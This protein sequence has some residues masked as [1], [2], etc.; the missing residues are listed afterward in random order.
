VLTFPLIILYADPSPSNDSVKECRLLG[1]IFP[2]SKNGTATE[3]RCF[4]RDP[5]HDVITTTVS[6]SAV[7]GS[8]ESVEFNQSGVT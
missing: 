1:N 4:L 5:R 6:E 2:I 7:Q 8:E 3:E